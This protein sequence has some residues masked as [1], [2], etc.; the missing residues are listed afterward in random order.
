M[1]LAK[2]STLVEMKAGRRYVLMK[3]LTLFD[4]RIETAPRALALLEAGWP[5]RAVSLVGDDLRFELRCFGDH[6]L[7]VRF[8]DI[9]HEVPGLVAPS[10]DDLAAILAHTRRLRPDDRLL[11]HCHAG[12]SRSP[13]MAIGMLI[14]NGMAPADAFER[15]KALRPILIPNR[16]MIAQLD[17]ILA[18]NGD[19]IEIVRKHYATLPPETSLPNRSEWNL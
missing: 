13:A 2:P 18:L 17:R 14:T 19:L 11:V 6:H 7:I 4:L 12:R 9:E 8:H 1:V 10:P 16:R 3:G 5:T 15:V